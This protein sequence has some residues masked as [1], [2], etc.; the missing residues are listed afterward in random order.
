[1]LTT[2]AKRKDKRS[3]TFQNYTLFNNGG[4]AFE[5]T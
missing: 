1:M 3:I 5:S 4:K 2:E